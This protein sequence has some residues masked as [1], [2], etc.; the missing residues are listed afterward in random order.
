MFVP[1]HSRSSTMPGRKIRLTWHYDPALYAPAEYRKACRYEAFLPD[2]LEN[3]AIALNGD[4]AG[5]VSD[6]EAAI[7]TLNDAARPALDPL[8]RLLLRTES[9]MAAAATGRPR[10]P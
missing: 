7:R 2:L 9:A 10:P 6:A 1:P 5:V 8:A 3:S 4:V